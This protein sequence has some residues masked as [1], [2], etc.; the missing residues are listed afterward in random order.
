MSLEKYRDDYYTFS[1]IASNV[2]RQLGFA[3]VAFIWL[4]KGDGVEGITLP[5]N[6]LWPAACLVLALTFDMLHYILASFIW[7]LFHRVHE[8][9]NLSS[10]EEKTL[11]APKYFNWPMLAMF[12]SKLF[13]IIAAYILLFKY[14]I[15]SIVFI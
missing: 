13:F 12:W 9:K 6:L 4:F 2:A 7:G 8:K 5:T 14:I 10:E 11:Q 15:E 1:G 3:G